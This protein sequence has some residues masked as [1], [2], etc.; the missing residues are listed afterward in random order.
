[1][2]IK[3]LEQAALADPLLAAFEEHP[4]KMESG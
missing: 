2:T 4:A 3:Y 1:M